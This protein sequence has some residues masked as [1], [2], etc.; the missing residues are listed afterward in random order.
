MGKQLSKLQALTRVD[1]EDK[2][3]QPL[4]SP[5]PLDQYTVTFF[6]VT[7]LKTPFTLLF[8]TFRDAIRVKYDRGGSA[9]Y[10]V[11]DSNVLTDCADGV[12]VMYKMSQLMTN[13]GPVEFGKSWMG[14]GWCVG[15]RVWWNRMYF[16]E[17]MRYQY[18]LEK[19]PNVWPK[20][21]KLSKPDEI[22][23]FRQR[24]QNDLHRMEVTWLELLGGWSRLLEIEMIQLERKIEILERMLGISTM[25][26]SSYKAIRLDTPGV[27]FLKLGHLMFT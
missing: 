26:G 13:R 10:V 14:V 4:I 24:L 19:H 3:S 27:R 15:G 8:S 12:Y 16:T 20:P 21:P 25:G 7:S 22:A 23:R 11:L 17:P 1:H 18:L 5:N 2:Q 9:S 6:H